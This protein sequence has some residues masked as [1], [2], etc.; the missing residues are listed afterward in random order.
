MQIILAKHAGFCFGVQRAMDLAWESLD[1]NAVIYSLG[2]LIHNSQAIKKYEESGLKTINSLS[3]IADNTTVIIRS[4]GVGSEVYNVSKERNINIIDA[5]CPFVKKIQNIVHEYQLNG[6]KII[7]VG[8]KNHPEV[9]G[10]NGWCNNE[11][12]I[13]KNVEDLDIKF[14]KDMK[15]CL[16]AQTTINIEVYESVVD[17]LKVTQKNIEFNNTICCATKERQE[18]AKELAKEVDLM[19]VIGGRHSSNTQKLVEVCSNIKPTMAIE[20]AEEL[21]SVDL[22]DINYVG[23]TAGASTPKWIIDQVVDYLQKY[24]REM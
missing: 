5:T 17:K 8:D 14:E 3:D 18:S 6:Y 4:H 20:T 22:S 23:I 7:I 13:I 2:P 15:Y 9:M 11:A 12:I 24:K 21:S 1:N 19:I 10:I 16:V